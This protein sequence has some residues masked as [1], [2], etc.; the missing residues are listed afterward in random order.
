MKFISE[1]WQKINTELVCFG[2]RDNQYGSFN[3]T[4]SGLL[5]TMKLVH[6][7]GSIK[8]NPNDPASY[9]GCRYASTYGTNGLM[10]IITNTKGEVILPSAG[11]LKAHNWCN[12]EQHFYSINGTHHTSPELVY[13]VL[14]NPLS[15]SRDQELQIW[16]GQD[17]IHCSEDDN[18]GTTCVDVYAWYA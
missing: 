5:K 12:T 1:N 6:K 14:P 2:A 7:S 13:R 9:W 3:I 10:T 15:V 18:N 16:Y 8:C 17:W 11:E 4:K